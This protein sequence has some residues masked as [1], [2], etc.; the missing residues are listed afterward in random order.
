MEPPN[1][2]RFSD[3]K[4]LHSHRIWLTINL[5]ALRIAC[6]KKLLL[7]TQYKLKISMKIKTVFPTR[8]VVLWTT[9]SMKNSRIII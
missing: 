2:S 6:R 1:T 7:H 4:A 8:R 5:S 9:L 3:A